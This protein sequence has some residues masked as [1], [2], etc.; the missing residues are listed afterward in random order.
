LNGMDASRKILI[1]AREIGESLE[2]SDVSVE[3][4]V[5]EEARSAETQDKFFEIL[6][7]YDQQMKEKVIDA[8]NRGLRLR[9][10][11]TLK[12]SKATVGLKEVAED[13]PFYQMK[14][15]DNIIAVYSKYYE[16]PLVIKGPGA[17]ANVTAAGI[18]AD[19][20]KA[21]IH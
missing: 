11:A 15:S 7:E 21:A 9:Y 12:D 5:P 10:V 4:L 19:L 1:L 13:H 16:T 8:E 17:G 6:A 18:M 14:G 2:L 3:N 20:L